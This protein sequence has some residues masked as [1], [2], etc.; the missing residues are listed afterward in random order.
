MPP[1]SFAEVGNMSMVEVGI[2]LMLLR[3]DTTRIADMANEFAAHFKLPVV[4][5]D[6]KGPFGRMIERRWIEPHPTDQNRVLVTRTGETITYSAF[7]GFVRLVDP[8][9][10]YF[11]AS[12]VY[13]LTT[14]QHEED[15][16]D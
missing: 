15:D 2:A 1:V 3:A 11:K 9:G 8:S 13:A 5:D 10:N 4:V 7:S 14:R 6:L 16:D 12:I